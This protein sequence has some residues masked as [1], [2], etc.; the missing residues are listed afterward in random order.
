MCRYYFTSY[1]VT[2]TCYRTSIV[3]ELLFLS[4]SCWDSVGI[5]S[6][7]LYVVYIRR[8]LRIDDYCAALRGAHA[9][10][11]QLLGVPPIS[12]K[13][14]SKVFMHEEY[15]NWILRTKTCIRVRDRS[16]IKNGRTF[17]DQKTNRTWDIVVTCARG[18]QYNYAVACT[19]CSS[20]G[21]TTTTTRRQTNPSDINVTQIRYS[22]YTHV[23]ATCRT[24]GK[25][26]THHPTSL[27]P[28]PLVSATCVLKCQEHCH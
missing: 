1:I 11:R 9:G 2:C 10:V 19:M 15:G 17:P 28:S 14:L 6:S 12:R 4:T 23:G 27:F 7:A 26:E 24:Q 16:R 5:I 20:S 21:V 3:P 8:R 25:T 18:N 13:M 22:T